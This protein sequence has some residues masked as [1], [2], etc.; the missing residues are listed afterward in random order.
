MNLERKGKSLETTGYEIKCFFGV[1]II[2]SLMR[3]HRIQQYWAHQTRVPI[4]ADNFTRSRFFTVRSNFKLVDDNIVSEN[5]KENDCFWKIRPIMLQVQRSC[6][7]NTR[8]EEISIDEQM[9]PFQGRCS[10]RQVIR[11]KP[12]PV[13]L[14]NV[15]MTTSD[16]IRWISFSTKVKAHQWSLPCT[17]RQKR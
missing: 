12:N 1:S 3:Y 2:I 4:V 14:R 7:Q 9:I 10:K 13:G 6:M 17:L 15:V 8:T 5:T 11:G 16:G